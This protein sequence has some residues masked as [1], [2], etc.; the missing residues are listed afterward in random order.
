ME[1]AEKQTPP[2]TLMLFIGVWF[3]SWKLTME[4]DPAKLTRLEQE[5]PGWL[6]KPDA[7]RKEV[8]RLVGFLGF[9]AKCVRPARIFLSRMLDELRLMPLRG[10]V[11]LSSDFKKDIYWWL[12]FMP[13]YNGVSMIPRPHWSEV[14]SVIATDACLTGCGAYNF[15]SGE[16]FHSEFPVEILNEQWSINELEL[17]TVMV[18]LKVWAGSLKAERFRIHCDNT[19]A[20]AAMNLSRVRNRHVQACMREIAFTAAVH[21]FEVL[22]VHVE[23][24]SNVLPDLLSRWHLGPQHS[25]RFRQLTSGCHISEIVLSEASFK[26]SGEWY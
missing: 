14:N 3:N 8:E 22:V 10:R 9:V 5:L 20:V 26:F 21:E 19:T 17:L 11:P 24:T 23:G 15:V 12:H 1:S 13:Q 18:A 6:S 16:F 4:V 7:S 2:N 25:E